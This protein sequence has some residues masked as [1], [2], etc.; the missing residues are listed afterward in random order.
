M[1][2]NENKYRGTHGNLRLGRACKTNG[3]NAHGSKNPP[4]LAVG[5]VKADS[6]YALTSSNISGFEEG[7]FLG[8]KGGFTELV[9][10]FMGKAVQIYGDRITNTPTTIRA[11]VQNRTAD[12][13][14]NADQRQILTQIGTLQCGQYIKFDNRWWLVV[15]LVDN[16]MVYEKAIIWYC[17][18]TVNFKSPKTSANVSYPVVTN[19][20]TQYNSGVESNKTMTVGSTQ[21][22]LFLPYNSETIEVDHDFRLLVDRRLSKPTAF[23]VT[24]VDTEQ[25]DY[26]GYGVLR[27]TL[28]EDILRS[29]DDIVNMVADNTP[30][31]DTGGD[32]DGGG[33][34]DAVT[35]EGGD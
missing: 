16:N 4:A 6:W 30:T 35:P 31:G 24:Q 2:L 22:L 11:I 17:N 25:Y 14:P 18:Y 3:G 21:R 29:T 26:D 8:D 9:N 33:W 19:N 23:K 27:W 10:S 15:S 28:S 20:A 13:P 5:S 34:L 32:D 12:T 7:N 1:L